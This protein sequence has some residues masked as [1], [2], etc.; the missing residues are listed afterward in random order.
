MSKYTETVRRILQQPN[1][2]VV[3]ATADSITQST[4]IAETSLEAKL[5]ESSVPPL[6][7]PS[8]PGTS[9]NLLRADR[10]VAPIIRNT[11]PSDA[12][13]VIGN[14]HSVTLA[15]SWTI[16]GTLIIATGATIAVL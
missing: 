15:G 4:A 13:V 14:G 5:L 10:I 16:D 6:M 2:T 7:F 3:L 12:T 9:T 11:V 8:S 1:H